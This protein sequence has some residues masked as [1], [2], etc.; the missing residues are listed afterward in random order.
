MYKFQGKDFLYLS[1]G[2]LIG[3]MIVVCANIGFMLAHVVL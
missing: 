1:W 3:V 2:I